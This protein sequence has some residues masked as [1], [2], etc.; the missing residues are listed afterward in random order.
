VIW[1]SCSISASS[2]T[3][4]ISRMAAIERGDSRWKRRNRQLSEYAPA[5]LDAIR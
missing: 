5:Q 1:A 2:H 3:L 4:T